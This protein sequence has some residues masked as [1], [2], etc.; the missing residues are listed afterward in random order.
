MSSPHQILIFREDADLEAAELKP[1]WPLASAQLLEISVRME[2]A[3][4]RIEVAAWGVGAYCAELRV[5]FQPLGL[6]RCHRDFLFR[7]FLPFSAP[8]A[9][10]F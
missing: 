3:A 4:L 7:A 6:I 5:S 8:M 1:Q 9:S 10:P 2:E